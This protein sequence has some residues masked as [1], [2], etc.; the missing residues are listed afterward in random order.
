MVWHFSWIK[1]EVHHHY[2][3]K[4]MSPY[5]WIRLNEQRACVLIVFLRSGGPLRSTVN[6]FISLP[7]V[8]VLR[9]LR[10]PRPLERISGFRSRRVLYSLHPLQSLFVDATT[11][12]ISISFVSIGI[13]HILLMIDNWM[14]AV[15]HFVWWKIVVSF[16]NKPSSVL[17]WHD[18]SMEDP[19]TYATK[20]MTLGLA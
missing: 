4:D 8:L 2:L 12:G 20:H 7:A 16:L 5:Q 3:F 11:G 19:I 15:V 10:I 6:L 18:F 1:I 17:R 9:A 13:K 14:Q